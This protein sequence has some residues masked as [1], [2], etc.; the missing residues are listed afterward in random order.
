MLRHN[1]RET[2]ST[3]SLRINVYLT[4][5]WSYQYWI[6]RRTTH[7]TKVCVENNQVHN[8]TDTAYCRRRYIARLILTVSF[9]NN[10]IIFCIHTSQASARRLHDILLC[11]WCEQLEERRT[12]KRNAHTHNAQ[13]NKKLTER[14]TVSVYGRKRRWNKKCFAQRFF[15]VVVTFFFGVSLAIWISH[16]SASHWGSFFSFS[17]NQAKSFFVDSFFES[18]YWFSKN[19]VLLSVLSS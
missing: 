9:N 15:V 7:R 16:F 10:H 4:R 2:H 8:A 18:T 19:Q 3:H 14:F 17:T 5:L 11:I 6:K 12:R 1:I 13:Q